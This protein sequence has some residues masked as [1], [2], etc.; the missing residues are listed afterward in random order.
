[1][2]FL[3]TNI[4]L[5]K[6]LRLYL[7][8]Q[9]FLSVDGRGHKLHCDTSW[10]CPPHRARLSGGS[11]RASHS[12]DTRWSGTAE[13]RTPSPWCLR[14]C[15]LGT[16]NEWPREM[17]IALFFLNHL[18]YWYSLIIATNLN[19]FHR[20]HEFVFFP[21]ALST[22][23]YKNPQQYKCTFVTFHS[24]WIKIL[25]ERRKEANSV[26]LNSSIKSK[27]IHFNFF[28]CSC[29]HVTDEKKIPVHVFTLLS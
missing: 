1:M 11:R 6:I 18:W 13:S 23:T 8:Y 28:F 20:N 12:R 29:T 14:Q 22:F 15:T 10:A 4:L 17:S 19:L 16:E 3:C 26:I 21:C 7:L 24:F 2:F 5:N 9:I 25:K 27:W